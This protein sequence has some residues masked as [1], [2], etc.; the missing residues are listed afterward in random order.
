MKRSGEGVWGGF[1]GRWK[2][3]EIED[4]EGDWR[5]MWGQEKC[6]WGLGEA[7]LL[8]WSRVGTGQGAS[9]GICGAVAKPSGLQG[10][11]EHPWVACLVLGSSPLFQG[12]GGNPS[13]EVA[14]GAK[15][16]CSMK[17][18]E[19][20]SVHVPKCKASNG[21]HSSGPKTHGLKLFC[22]R[23]KATWRDLRAVLLLFKC[24]SV[25]EL[26]RRLQLHHVSRSFPSTDGILISLGT[27]PACRPMKW[28]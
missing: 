14:V 15:V 9:E 20:F 24:R 10:P 13:T 21:S 8:V 11:P 27:S 3:R 5:R 6:R 18:L 12:R 2:V 28:I 19:G 17:S 4:P 22:C 23:L 16:H 1:R 7:G 25:E 26:R